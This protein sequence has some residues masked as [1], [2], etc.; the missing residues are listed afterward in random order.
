VLIK[1]VKQVVKA[2]LPR[3]AKDQL[4]IRAMVKF[5]SRYNGK[6]NSEIFSDIYQSGHWGAGD[7]TFF[8]GSGSHDTAIIT[9]YVE[10]ISNFLSE[11]P[12]QVDVVD[13]GCGDFNVGSQIRELC[14]NYV[15]CDVVPSLIAHNSEKFRELKVDFRCIDIARDVL[16]QG[17]VVFIRQVLQH[18]SNHDI[19]QVVSKLGQYRYLVLTEHLP[20]SQFV[21]NIDKPAGMGIRLMANS[22]IILTRPPF[23]LKVS[24]ER[25]LC[26]VPEEGGIIRT[27]LY[28]MS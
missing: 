21:A 25:I 5:E 15:A 6:A 8:S 2:A 10:A 22:G 27:T 14:G 9:P 1:S 12:G 24:A 4:A 18:L 13:L 7:A 23:S 20:V 28:E 16:P 19:L 3:W 11:L 26:E 17:D